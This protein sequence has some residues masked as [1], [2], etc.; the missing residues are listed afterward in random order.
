LTCP[1]FE[2]AKRGGMSTGQ[3]FQVLFSIAADSICTHPIGLPFLSVAARDHLY[4]STLLIL[5]LHVILRISAPITGSRD[6]QRT[7]IKTPG[8]IL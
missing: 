8:V 5:P 4:D 6:R 2:F 7:E 1:T 3:I